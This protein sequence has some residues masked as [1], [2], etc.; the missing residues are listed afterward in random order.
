MKVKVFHIRLTKENLQQ[1]QDL[2]NNFLVNVTVKKTAT[3]LIIAQ[4]NFW[5]I[6]VFYED[7]KFNNQ[8]KQSAKISV[9]ND[10]ELTVNEKQIF[11]SLR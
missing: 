11:K 4:P 5:S 6:L 3:E 1:D 7:Q 2:L 8:E 10:V 9:T